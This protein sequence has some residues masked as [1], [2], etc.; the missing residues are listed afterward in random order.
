MLGL[1]NNEFP[2][3]SQKY[4]IKETTEMH[5]K[6]KFTMTVNAWRQRHISGIVLKYNRVIETYVTTTKGTRTTIYAEAV[7]GASRDVA[8]R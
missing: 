2:A 8:E 5:S 7:T 3:L 6:S 4:I 1:N